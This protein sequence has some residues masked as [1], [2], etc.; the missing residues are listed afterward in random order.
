MKLN[1]NL[2]KDDVLNFY[3][4]HHLKSPEGKKTFIK[5]Y[6]KIIL[7]SFILIVGVFISQLVIKEEFY[8]VFGMIALFLILY[9]VI[10]K[11][12]TR[13]YL[14]RY[15]NKQDLEDIIGDV[16]L[17]IEGNHLVFKSNSSNTSID[18]NQ[19][20]RVRETDQY[21]FIFI[22]DLNAFIIPKNCSESLKVDNFIELVKKSLIV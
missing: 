15:T 7:F 10:Y 3:L 13:Y 9:P 20:M 8:D 1:F 16:E 12:I 14:K 19:I 5:L 18:I 2:T 11:P 21:Y 17:A 22:S 4:D 6:K